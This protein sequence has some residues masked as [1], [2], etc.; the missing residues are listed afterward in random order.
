MRW[1]QLEP[2][3]STPEYRVAPLSKTSASVAAR[4]NEGKKVSSLQRG[5]PLGKEKAAGGDFPSGRTR[6]M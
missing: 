3:S 2:R 1:N 6:E 5:P 4:C